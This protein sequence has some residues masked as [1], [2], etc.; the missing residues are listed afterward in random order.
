[1]RMC[2]Y[3]NNL[4]DLAILSTY[5]TDEVIISSTSLDIS[6]LLIEL[7]ETEDSKL[8]ELTLPFYYSNWNE[9]MYLMIYHDFTLSFIIANNKPRAKIELFYV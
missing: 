3:K 4:I 6:S 5:I 7:K 2:E 8:A 1:M 9:R